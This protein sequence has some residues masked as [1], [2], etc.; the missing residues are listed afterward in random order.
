MINII[1][2]KCKRIMGER[3]RE[4]TNNIRIKFVCNQC[5]NEVIAVI[6]F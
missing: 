6:G 2:Q 1:C 5:Q 4:V 3:D